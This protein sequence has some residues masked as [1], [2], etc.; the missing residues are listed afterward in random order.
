[1][2]AASVEDTLF[3]PG[4]RSAGILGGGLLDA[5]L[6]GIKGINRSVFMPDENVRLSE[7]WGETG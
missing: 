3:L 2:K 4:R 6:F 1:M 5:Q 7:S